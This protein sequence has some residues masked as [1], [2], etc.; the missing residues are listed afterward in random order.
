MWF[1]QSIF[2]QFYPLGVCGAPWQNQ[3][4]QSHAIASLVDWIPHLQRLGINAVYF[5]P[6]F[7]SDAHGY[8]TRD[9]LRID[10]G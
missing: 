5:S 3:G 8:D 9:Y 7:D 2:Y 1:T 10:P 6:V 4:Q